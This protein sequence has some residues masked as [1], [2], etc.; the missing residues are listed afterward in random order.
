MSNFS[1]NAKGKEKREER[2]KCARETLDKTFHDLGKTTF[3]VMVVGSMSTF[4]G[5]TK[6]S[7]A[8]IFGPII[9]GFILSFILISTGNR[10][11]KHK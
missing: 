1:N 6:Y 8:Q 3:A 5:L 11:I 9:T 10:I 7:A 4:F 2:E